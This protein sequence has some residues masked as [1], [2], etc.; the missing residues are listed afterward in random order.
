MIDGLDLEDLK[1][2]FAKLYTTMVEISNK[3]LSEPKNG[4][5]ATN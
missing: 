1:I 5:K 4:G 3:A 2:L